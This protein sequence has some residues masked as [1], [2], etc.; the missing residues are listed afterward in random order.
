MLVLSLS[1]K[2]RQTI[3]KIG[4]GY[5]HGR[6]LYELIWGSCG[7]S[8]EDDWYGSTDINFSVPKD[9]ALEIDWIGKEYDYLWPGFSYELKQKLNKLCD[10]L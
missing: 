8:D 9:V 10:S 4:G 2:E 3:T 6:N 7:C 1:A 5:S